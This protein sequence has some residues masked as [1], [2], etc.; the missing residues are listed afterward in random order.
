M[1]KP[2]VFM[3]MVTQINQ[4]HPLADGPVMLVSDTLTLLRRQHAKIRAMVKRARENRAKGRLGAMVFTD[5]YRQACDDLLAGLGKLKE[6][7]P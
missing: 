5:G 2:D 7:K 3:Q 6:W 1:K 4:L